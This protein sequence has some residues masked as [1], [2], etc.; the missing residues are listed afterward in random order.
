M[1]Y[2]PENAD[3]G[4]FE[5]GNEHPET[6][7]KN[8]EEYIVTYKTYDEYFTDFDLPSEMSGTTITD[9]GSLYSPY[10]INSTND[11]IFLTTIWLNQ[12]HILLIA[13]S[14]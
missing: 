4:D 3:N 9:N 14:F 12:K 10:E 1:L 11:F 7:E 8:E 2:S 13:T 6:D 5:G